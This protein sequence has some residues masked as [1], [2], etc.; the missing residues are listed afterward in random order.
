MIDLN[1]TPQAVTTARHPLDPLTAEEIAEAA[2]IVRGVETLADAV[3]F[4][5]ISLREPPKAQVLSYRDGDRI[6]REAFVVARQVIERATY[7]IMVSTTA[8]RVVSLRRL[9]MCSQP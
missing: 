7:E 5:S 3:R 1:V 9:G 6:E 8:G 2:R 4:V